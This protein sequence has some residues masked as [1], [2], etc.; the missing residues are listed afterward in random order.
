MHQ[1]GNHGIRALAECLAYW[2][3]EDTNQV[4]VFAD[5]LVDLVNVKFVAQP[6]ICQARCVNENDLLKVASRARARPNRHVVKQAREPFLFRPLVD[7]LAHEW[8]QLDYIVP[9]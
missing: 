6:T 3:Q 9:A 5:P 1:P 8:Q 4:T 2:V 7:K